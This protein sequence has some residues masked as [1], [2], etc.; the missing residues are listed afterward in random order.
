MTEPPPPT[1][2]FHDP[3][4]IMSGS[5]VLSQW[6]AGQLLDSALFR[7]IAALDRLAIVLRARAGM[8]IGSWSPAFR[9]KELD[10]LAP[11]YPVPEWQ[12][13]YALLENPIWGLTKGMRDGFTHRQR[14]PADLHGTTNVAVDFGSMRGIRERL[15]SDEHL[16]VI[17]AFYSLILKPAVE[18]TGAILGRP[19]GEA[20][21]P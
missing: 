17:R 5:R 8:P 18:L 16:A 19:A 6:L 2:L 13:L 9:E 1:R 15:S 12:E 7:S 10:A 20:T 21:S 14:V 4:Q 3:Y 11:A